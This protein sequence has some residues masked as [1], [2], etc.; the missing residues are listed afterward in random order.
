M[1]FLL[2]LVLI[3]EIKGTGFIIVIKGTLF[4][5]GTITAIFYP[6][7][8]IFLTADITCEIHI[9]DIGIIPVSF[10]PQA[11]PKA[12]TDIIVKKQVIIRSN[13]TLLS[14]YIL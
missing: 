7:P 9:K 4:N 3:L 6:V 14:R 13:L 12:P 2:N 10:L 1:Q 8:F 5:G 11:T